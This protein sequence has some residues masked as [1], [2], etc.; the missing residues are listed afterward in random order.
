MALMM[1][2]SEQAGRT[3][4]LTVKVSLSGSTGVA[5]MAVLLSDSESPH[6]FLTENR[7][8]VPEAVTAST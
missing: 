8:F 1:R 7:A 3:L 4:Y 6:S 2:I 5:V